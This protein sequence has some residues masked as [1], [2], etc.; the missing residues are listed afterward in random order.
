ML[1]TSRMLRRGFFTFCIAVPG[2]AILM[3]GSLPPRII[4]VVA[5]KDNRFKIAKQKDPVITMRV[6]EVA[7]L[8]ITAHRAMEWDDKDG[9][10]HTFT[11]N[12]LKSKGWDFRLKDGVQQFPVVAPSEPGEYVVECTVKCG[13]GHDDMKM[14]LVVTP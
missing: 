12:A 14:K 5:D 10:V 1:N 8:R 3:A 4:D 11:I 13:K 7:V 6:N 9:S 2:L